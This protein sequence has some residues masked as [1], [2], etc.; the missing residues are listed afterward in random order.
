MGNKS[1]M[2]KLPGIRLGRRNAAPRSGVGSIRN[3]RFCDDCGMP[4]CPHCDCCLMP[5]WP[6]PGTFQC[7]CGFSG[8]VDLDALPAEV[9]DA[10]LSL[11]DHVR[12]PSAH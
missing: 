3:S 11:W 9:A 5:V 10:V 12:R 1:S 2:S 8:M 4:N 7:Q 6:M